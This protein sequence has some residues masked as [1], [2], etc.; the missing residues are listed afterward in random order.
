MRNGQLQKFNES[1]IFLPK[2]LNPDQSSILNIK[3]NKARELNDL[4]PPQ[5]ITNSKA[6][7]EKVNNEINNII[8]TQNDLMK[9]ISAEKHKKK[10]RFKHAAEKYESRIQL[11]EEKVFKS[12]ELIEL[13]RQLLDLQGMKK[14]EQYLYERNWDQYISYQSMHKIIKCHEEFFRIASTLSFFEYAM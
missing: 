1:S 3:K 10:H 5:I 8:D 4:R 2:D 12:Q 14:K 7:K 6:I 9:R 13:Q 11:M